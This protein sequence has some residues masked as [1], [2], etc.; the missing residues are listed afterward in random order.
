MSAQALSST[1]NH[2]YCHTDR[3]PVRRLLSGARTVILGQM[4][5]ISTVSCLPW[6]VIV[7]SLGNNSHSTRIQ[8]V[9]TTK[10]STRTKLRRFYRSIYDTRSIVD[11]DE[12]DYLT[13]TPSNIAVLLYEE[14]QLS[15]VTEGIDIQLCTSVPKNFFKANALYRIA[16]S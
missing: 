15:P 2:S 9:N 13:N 7:H 14:L 6:A 4:D 3:S 8:L 5:V 10:L 16:Y 11:S 1:T 12:C